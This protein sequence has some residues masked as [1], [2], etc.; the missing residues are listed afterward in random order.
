MVGLQKIIKPKVVVGEPLNNM[1]KLINLI[2]EV[3]VGPG[4]ENDR[5]MVVGV[6]EIL[7]M[8]DDMNN[9]KEIAEAML[10]KF[11][12]E[13]VIHNAEEFLTLCGI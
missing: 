11:K 3:E 10:R 2:N 1:I 8:V 5:D 9:R 12:S 13:D 4:H 6:A 7:R